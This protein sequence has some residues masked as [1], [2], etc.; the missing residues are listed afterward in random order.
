MN[1]FKYRNNVNNTIFI[2][3]GAYS[4]ITF[5]S[6]FLFKLA[7]FIY[8]CCL[9]RLNTIK[10]YLKCHKWLKYEVVLLNNKCSF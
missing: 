5:L 4:T 8:F 2:L 3:S 6:Q 10:K 9:F 1:Y 7:D